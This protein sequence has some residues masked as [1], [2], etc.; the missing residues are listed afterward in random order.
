MCK[1]VIVAGGKPVT[2]TNCGSVEWTDIRKAANKITASCGT[3]G[4]R[5]ELTVL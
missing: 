5:L 1:S 2:C 4:R 3:C